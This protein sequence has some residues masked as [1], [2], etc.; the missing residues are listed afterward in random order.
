MSN[1][2]ERT[3]SWTHPD[4]DESWNARLVL[5]EEDWESEDVEPTLTNEDNEPIP[6]SSTIY[7]YEVV[8]GYDRSTRTIEIVPPR[9]FF[10]EWRVGNVVLY[11]IDMEFRGWYYR[12]KSDNMDHSFVEAFF[13]SNPICNMYTINCVLENLGYGLISTNQREFIYYP[14]DIDER[15]TFG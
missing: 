9:G 5:G 11:I 14:F 15:Y 12:A 6:P 2:N 3:P 13:S 10:Y 4:V 7:P 8:E 1:N